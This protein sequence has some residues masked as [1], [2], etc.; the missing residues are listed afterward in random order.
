MESTSYVYSLYDTSTTKFDVPL[1][2]IY[3][4]LVILLVTIPATI[5]PAA[6]IIHII[7]KNEEL[8]TN[9]SLFLVNLLIGD[10]LTTIRY[11]FEVI[12]KILYLLSVRVYSRVQKKVNVAY[13]NYYVITDRSTNCYLPIPL[14]V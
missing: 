13:R 9:Y 7:R 4:E 10:I 2:S 11:C 6:V 12:I 1:V 8:H 3:L 14:S 5:T